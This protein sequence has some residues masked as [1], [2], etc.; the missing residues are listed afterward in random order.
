MFKTIEAF[1][2]PFLYWWIPF[3]ILIHLKSK[4]HAALTS[5]FKYMDYLL[6]LLLL[7]FFFVCFF[8]LFYV[9]SFFFHWFIWGTEYHLE[10]EKERKR[11]ACIYGSIIHFSIFQHSCMSI[12]LNSRIGKLFL[13]TSNRRQILCVDFNEWSRVLTCRRWLTYE[14]NFLDFSCWE[15]NN[16]VI[17]ISLL[18]YCNSFIDI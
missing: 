13:I 6:M 17:S 10:R 11:F 16:I 15:N 7:L 4:R 3:Y 12:D 9:F 2:Y 18:G 5:S 1:M 14:T 8:F